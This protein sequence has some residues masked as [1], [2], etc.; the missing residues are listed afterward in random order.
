MMNPCL[1]PAQASARSRNLTD[2]KADA[3]WTQM[4]LA[5]F[6]PNFRERR[7]PLAAFDYSPKQRS[8]KELWRSKGRLLRSWQ[9]WEAQKRRKMLA[10]SD[11]LR[12]GSSNRGLHRGTRASADACPA[13]RPAGRQ[14]AAATRSCQAKEPSPVGGLFQLLP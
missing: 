12:M 14:A 8:G 2:S 6:R 10:N 9:P 7:P 1:S 3:S 11:A 5:K 4:P 13:V